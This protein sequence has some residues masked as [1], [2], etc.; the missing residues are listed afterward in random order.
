MS[1]KE[2]KKEEKHTFLLYFHFAEDVFVVV[3][4]IIEV[5]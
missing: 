5:I 3:E 1:K 2:E 4:T